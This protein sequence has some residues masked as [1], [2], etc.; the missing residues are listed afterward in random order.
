MVVH[1]M[2]G[3]ANIDHVAFFSIGHLPLGMVIALVCIGT[4]FIDE[5]L[6]LLE[7]GEHECLLKVLQLT[8]SLPAFDAIAIDNVVD[9][10]LKHLLPL[11]FAQL[12][13][14]FILHSKFLMIGHV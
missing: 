14:F 2:R 4:N 12:V 10:G 3:Q 6:S 8:D 1:E 11:S 9:A 7:V 13:E 5:F